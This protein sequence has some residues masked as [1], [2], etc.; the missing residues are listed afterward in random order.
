M[1]H[2]HTCT[3]E[4]AYMRKHVILHVQSLAIDI[5]IY[6]YAYVCKWIPIYIYICLC[7]CIEFILD[8]PCADCDRPEGIYRGTS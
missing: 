6:T 4:Y 2:L 3:H 8:A 5:N 1:H 7:I